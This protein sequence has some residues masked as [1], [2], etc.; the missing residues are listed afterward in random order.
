MRDVQRVWTDE[1]GADVA[2]V[3]VGDPALLS[4]AARCA[5]ISAPHICLFAVTLSSLARI[6]PNA[7]VLHYRS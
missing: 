5:G 2:I 7:D 4:V 3:A 1:A 6:D